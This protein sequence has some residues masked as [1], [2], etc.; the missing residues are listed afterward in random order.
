MGNRGK[1]WTKDDDERLLS[2]IGSGRDLHCASSILMR[3]TN[4][5][6][7]RLRTIVFQS[8]GDS[9]KIDS[10]KRLGNSIVNEAI[11]QIDTEKNFDRR[12]FIKGDRVLNE[13]KIFKIECQLSSMEEHMLK[14]KKDLFELKMIMY[15]NDEEFC[16][17]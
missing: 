17:I 6:K 14:L 13:T 9:E 12:K 3:S 5:V 10:L 1:L 8:I 7:Y 16:L 4:S 11:E 2:I 15:N